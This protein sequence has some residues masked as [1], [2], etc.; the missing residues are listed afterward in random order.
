MAW[1][2]KSDKPEAQGV[3]QSPRAKKFL[4]PRNFTLKKESG[5]GDFM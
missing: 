4:L 5:V 2:E 1:E 3:N